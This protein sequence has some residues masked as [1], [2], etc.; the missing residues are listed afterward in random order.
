MIYRFGAIAGAALVVLLVAW[1]SAASKPDS[2]DVPGTNQSP[3]YPVTFN[4]SAQSPGVATGRTDINGRAITVPCQTC[5]SLLQPAPVAGALSL[6]SLDRF[7][8]GLEFRH[9]SLTC[10]S[11]HDVGQPQQFKLADAIPVE[12]WDAMQLCSQCHGP[13]RRDYDHGAHGGM[14]A[15][16]DLTRAP[17]ARNIC[18]DCHDPHSPKPG[19]VLPTFKP[20]DRFMTP[21]VGV[22]PPEGAHD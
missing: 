18:T 3:T 13:Q 17:R 4:R 11:C 5:H 1:H 12:S 10:H 14:N 19:Q 2:T 8:R 9:G 21:A 20:K 6:G 22:H 7:H 15:S 16:C